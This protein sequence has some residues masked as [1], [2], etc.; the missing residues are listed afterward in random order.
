MKVV[1]GPPAC[2]SEPKTEL[3]EE[4]E[5]EEEPGLKVPKIEAGAEATMQPPKALE[6]LPAKAKVKTKLKAA[7]RA[8]KREASATTEEPA[9]KKEKVDL[10][11][12]KEIEGR[13]AE[14]TKPTA[15]KKKAIFRPQA[16][17][18]GTRN[19]LRPCFRRG[20]AGTALSET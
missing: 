8:A 20:R 1:K 17:I 15:E 4:I 14:K 16:E 13:E 10:C 18:V 11:S 5:I 19:T 2:K 7:K 3:P 6:K 12:R 9:A